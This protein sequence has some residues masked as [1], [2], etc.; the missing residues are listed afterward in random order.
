MIGVIW[1]PS[2]QTNMVS[3][4]E[5]YPLVDYSNSFLVKRRTILNPILEE[6]W[7]QLRAGMDTPRLGRSKK[8]KGS[9]YLGVMNTRGWIKFKTD[10]QYTPG[11]Q[12]SQ[13]IKL[14]DIKDLPYVEDDMTKRDIIRLMLQG[15][16]KVHCSCPDFKFRGFK[17][18]GYN[19]DYGIY[20]ELRFPRIRNPE[21]EGTVCKHLA[22]VFGVYMFNWSKIARDMQKTKY[23]RSRLS[24]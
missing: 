18:L 2:Y 14:M 17:Y 13:Y 15:D 21:L 10:S 16:I 11:K 20:R 1:L 4:F 9:Y 5:D 23:F 12:Y 3:L 24:V 19:L 6:T 7:K 8:I 22:K